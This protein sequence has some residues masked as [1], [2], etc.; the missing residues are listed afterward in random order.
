MTEAQDIATQLDSARRQFRDELIAAELL[1]PMGIDGLYGRGAV[2]ES[3]VDGIDYAVRGKGTEV[4]GDDPKVMRFPAV[5][6]REQFEKTDYIASFPDL[7]GAISTFTGGNAEHRALL[8]DR[9]AG[10]PW[11]GHLN[12]AGTMLVSAACHPSYATLPSNLPDGGVLMDIYGYCFRHEPSV[13]PARMQAFRMHEYVLAGTPDQAQEHRD[14]WAGHA[15]EVLTE[16]GLDARP[17][18]ANDPFFGR[19]GKMLAA[20]Q[21]DENL[22]TE[23]L[24]RLYGDLHEGT[25]VASAN[26][27]REH[28]GEAFNLR[29]ADGEV[30]HSA[31][32]GFGIERIALGMLRTHGFDPSSWPTEVRTAMGW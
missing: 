19:A 17:A 2:F 10:L 31:C 5:Y 22:K 6:P 29:S 8:A 14:S 9:N 30:A 28:F 3:I 11:D 21:R 1:V 20:N 26:C 24:V 13:D 12:S 27:H 4:H 32:V 16:L 25:A 18:P 23:L 7:T 15:L